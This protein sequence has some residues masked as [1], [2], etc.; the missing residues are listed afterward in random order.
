MTAAVRL[1][2]LHE[3]INACRVCESCV[4][5]FSKPSSMNRGEVGDVLIVGESPGATEV[6]TQAA[7]SG[8]AGTRLNGWL[9]QCGAEEADPRRSV[10]LTSVVKC[11]STNKPALSRMA[12]NCAPFMRQQID[13][14]APRIV[15][16]LGQFAYDAFDTQLRWRD[17]VCNLYESRELWLLSPFTVPFKFMVWPHPSGLSRWT[18]NPKNQRRLVE[19]F[20]AVRGARESQQGSP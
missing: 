17:A 8:Q 4:A 16:T 11:R 5:D 20:A 18:N 2:R 10:Y 7:F 9:V 13:I 19:S 1:R 6:A 14:V 15:I 12:K 3:E